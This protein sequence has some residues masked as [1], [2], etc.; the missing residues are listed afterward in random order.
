VKPP[1]EEEVPVDEARDDDPGGAQPHDDDPGETAPD[2]D[3]DPGETAPDRDD[4]PGLHAGDDEP[5]DDHGDED[6]EDQGRDELEPGYLWTFAEQEERLGGDHGRHMEILDDLEAREILGLD[7]AQAGDYLL[8]AAAQSLEEQGWTGEALA[9]LRRLDGSGQPHP[10]LSYAEIRLRLHD[11]LRERGEYNEALQVLERVE[12]EDPARRDACRERRAEVLVLTGRKEEGLRLYEKVMRSVPD[13][14]WPPLNAAWALIRAGDYDLALSWI[15]RGERAANR[16]ED[17]DEAQ[18]A[19]N[20]IERLRNESRIRRE[21]RQRATGEGPEALKQAI[22]ADLD[23]EEVRLTREPP[24]EEAD[25]E[26]ALSRLVELHRRASA[27]WDDAVERHDEAA[28]S[29]FDDLGWEV[30]EVAERFGLR[31]PGTEEE[32]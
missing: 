26:A 19:V 9:V 21:R 11:L 15:G 20:E 32:G 3:D 31:I 17:E 6:E 23:A 24:R 8:W 10:A 30:V 22:L 1:D 16:L 7:L 27:A 13:D 18:P 25:R 29:T 5:F 12:Q 4:D 28:I 14:P 2:R